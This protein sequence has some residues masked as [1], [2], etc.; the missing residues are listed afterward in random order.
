MSRSWRAHVWYRDRVRKS[1]VSLCAL[2]LFHFLRD[3]KRFHLHLP[4]YVHRIWVFDCGESLTLGVSLSSGESP[5]RLG[6]NQQPASTTI[7]YLHF[8][9]CFSNS[10]R[11]CVCP[12]TRRYAL[13]SSMVLKVHE[14]PTLCLGWHHAYIDDTNETCYVVFKSL[15]TLS[16]IAFDMWVVVLALSHLPRTHMIDRKQIHQHPDDGAVRHSPLA[17]L[18]EN[19]PSSPAHDHSHACGRHRHNDRIAGERARADAHGRRAARLALHWLLHRG[20][21][22]Q[23][24][25][26]LLG[27]SKICEQ[28][29]TCYACRDLCAHNQD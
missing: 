29:A 19:R 15:V 14:K 24:A 9:S 27:D 21:H 25:C 18:F 23:R 13:Y 2:L 17:S 5:S 20:H 8:M 7:L 16:L 6:S 11:A 12:A 26:A 28:P 22:R 4:Q 10:L 3:L 1:G